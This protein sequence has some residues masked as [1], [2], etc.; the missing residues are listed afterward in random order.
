M[1]QII[2]QQHEN[3]GVTPVWLCTE[4]VL[5]P[6]CEAPPCRVTEL[7]PPLPSQVPAVTTTSP[8]ARDRRWHGPH[9]RQPRSA[10]PVSSLVSIYNAWRRSIILASF[11]L[12]QLAASPR[13]PAPAHRRTPPPFPWRAH[14]NSSDLL[15]PMAQLSRPGSVP[16]Q[17]QPPAKISPSS[18]D[19]AQI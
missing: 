7:Q 4:P 1:Q 17:T 13:D 9:H 15:C 10:A 2:M 16:A 8:V 14:V 18:H 5:P 6:H 3:Q 19:P 11:L 12:S